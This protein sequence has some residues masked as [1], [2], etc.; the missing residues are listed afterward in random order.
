MAFIMMAK[1]TVNDTKYTHRTTTCSRINCSPLPC[2][3]NLTFMQML[4]ASNYFRLKK[5]H[6][7]F[8]FSKHVLH[9]FWMVSKM[10][11]YMH[12]TT[13]FR[14]F[15]LFGDKNR[16]QHIEGIVRTKWLFANLSAPNKARNVYQL[17][18]KWNSQCECSSIA[19]VETKNENLTHKTIHDL[20]LVVD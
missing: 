6:V 3:S 5:C 19:W 12:S 11:E 1:I 20:F 8:F 13:H 15:S 2:L 7:S 14:F 4:L 18:L 10:K 9:A 17:R 16:L